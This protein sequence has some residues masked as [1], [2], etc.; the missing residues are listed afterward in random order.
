MKQIVIILLNFIL[1]NNAY[2][3]KNITI[4]QSF[5]NVEV[6]FLTGFYY[7]EIN[8]ALMI[9][10]YAEKLSK[11]M[12]FD[13]Q[14]TLFFKHNI[15]DY[16][17]PYYIFN[18][19]KTKEIIPG[20]I[21]LDMKDREFNVLDIL[22]L[23][24]YSIANRNN[25][26]D[27]NALVLIE[28]NKNKKSKR[29]QTV[30]ENKIYRPTIVNELNSLN[31]GISY[32]YKNDSFHVFR[33]ENGKEKILFNFQSIYQIAQIDESSLLIFDTKESFYYFSKIKWKNSSK[34]YEIKD[35]Q[36]LGLPYSV[37]KLSNNL[38]SITFPKF[39]S[40]SDKTERVMLLDV[41]SENVIQD[42]REF[43]NK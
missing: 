18:N 33:K 23:I 20:E 13:N 43:F 24:E 34:K 1:F 31:N 4:T 2:A 37:Y 7:E 14:I 40:S 29:I 22:N 9:G 38:I 39:K 42:I 10:Q 26:N 16:E 32:F 25:I 3:H 8:K 41:K 28:Q 19:N 15:D 21:F 12:N 36:S 27:L 17:E 35:D 30:V 5:G 11:A 6:I